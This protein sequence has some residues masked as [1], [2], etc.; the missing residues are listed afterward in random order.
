MH[1]RCLCM[2]EHASDQNCFLSVHVFFKI[3]IISDKRLAVNPG[4]PFMVVAKM[5]TTCSVD[6]FH[7]SCHDLQLHVLSVYLSW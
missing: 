1:A 4:V 6:A 5:Y 7:G 3:L 2:Q